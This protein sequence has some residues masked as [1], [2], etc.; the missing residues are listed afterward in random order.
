M[1]VFTKHAIESNTPIGEGIYV[2]CYL[3]QFEN[4][5]IN[6]VRNFKNYNK[7]Y[8]GKNALVTENKL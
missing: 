6:Y 7:K 3:V 5:R 1:L 8:G 2:G 4:Y